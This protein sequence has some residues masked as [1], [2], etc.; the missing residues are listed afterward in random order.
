MEKSNSFKN[1]YSG[2][3]GA[4]GKP[5][6]NP[7]A[8]FGI[9]WIDVKKLKH[10]TSG[11]KQKQKFLNG[12]VEFFDPQEFVYGVKEIFIEEIYNQVLGNSPYIIDCGAHI[13][14]SVIYLKHKFPDADIIA[15]EPDEKNFELLNC[16]LLAQ[17]IDDVVTKKAAVWVDKTV[18]QFNSKGNMSSKIDLDSKESSNNVNTERLKDY[19]N[20]TV[21]FLKIDIEGAEFTVLKDIKESL[22]NVKNLFVEY[23]GNFTQANELNQILSWLTEYNFSFYIQEATKVFPQPFNKALRNTTDYDIQLNI[24]AFN[25]KK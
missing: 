13:G 24:Y 23:H 5:F 25:D 2:I 11:A 16:N 15:F 6:K 19:L 1:L 17:G 12:H 8:A 22:P 4:L 14:L 18:L 7:F 3:I 21:D 20:R 9:S 10:G